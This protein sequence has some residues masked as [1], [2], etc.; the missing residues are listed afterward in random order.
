MLTKQ[1]ENFI[2]YWENNRSRKKKFLRQFSIGLPL[3]VLIVVVLF[4]N[5]FSG[6]YERADMVL[7]SNSSLIIVILIAVVGI[8]VFVTVFASRHKWD[9]NEQRYQELKSK[10]A[11]ASGNGATD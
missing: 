3:S 9:Q 2:R 5:V 8:S 4:F 7:R 10:K 11:K 1:E 6:W